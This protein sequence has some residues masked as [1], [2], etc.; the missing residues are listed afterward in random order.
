MRC[1]TYPYPI[2][3]LRHWYVTPVGGRSP[4]LE[5]GELGLNREAIVENTDLIP[6]EDRV[7]LS[8]LEGGSPRPLFARKY[9][10]IVPLD[11]S[12]PDAL[13]K[14]PLGEAIL[15]ASDNETGPIKV[16]EM[17][18]INSVL[19]RVHTH[20]LP[21]IIDRMIRSRSDVQML[22]VIYTKERR[23]S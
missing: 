20:G 1:L 9:F 16:G 12:K 3:T 7:L 2:E 21:S 22:D 10:R 18:V 8:R 19:S 14:S 4:E 5:P 17:V 6:F 13:S 15:P 23:Q 11:R